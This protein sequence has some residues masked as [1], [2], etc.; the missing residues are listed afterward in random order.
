MPITDIPPANVPRLLLDG[1]LAFNKSKVA[2]LISPINFRMVVLQ[3][4]ALY[5][6][7]PG[8]KALLTSDQ[9]GRQ[10]IIIADVDRLAMVVRYELESASKDDI[11]EH[12]IS[13]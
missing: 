9:R 8:Q 12:P 11:L 13:E 4:Q 7:I 10:P 1:E 6:L 3:S 2:V 5:E